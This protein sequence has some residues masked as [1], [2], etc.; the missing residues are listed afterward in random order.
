MEKPSSTD[1]HGELKQSRG[2]RKMQVFGCFL[3]SRCVR[4]RLHKTNIPQN[5]TINT[6]QVIVSK[7]D[8]LRRL[9]SLKGKKKQKTPEHI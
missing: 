9:Y 2:D 6:I 3:W 5:I 4:S 8:K 7:K 1:H